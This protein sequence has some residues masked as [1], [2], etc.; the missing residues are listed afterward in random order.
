MKNP[1]TY[2]LASKPNG[3][4]YVGVTSDLHGRMSEHVQ[5][6][7]EGFTKKHN[8]KQLVYY[9]FHHTMPEAIHR[10]KLIKDW[11]RHWKIR[12]IEAMNPKWIN[13]YNES[14]G[15]IVQGPADIARINH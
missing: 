11:H 13:L 1:C 9:E 8:V 6:M 10:E 2:I 14:N 12:L 4:L 5:G 7:F 15:D 3:T